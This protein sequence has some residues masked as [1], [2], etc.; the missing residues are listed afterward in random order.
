MIRIGLDFDG[1]MH[2]SCARSHA[3]FCETL[4]DHGLDEVERDHMRS[5]FGSDWGQF[6]KEM[7]IPKELHSTWKDAYQARYDKQPLGDLIEGTHELLDHITGR[8]G[9]KGLVLITNELPDRVHRFMQAHGL[10]HLESTVMNAYSGKSGLLES[11]E[12]TAY[13]GDTVSD[14]LACITARNKPRFFGIANDTSYNMPEMLYALRDAHPEHPI[15]IVR[16]LDEV[17]KYI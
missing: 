4:R 15:Q 10:E 16:R 13:V 12:V 8:Y 7:G 5:Y 1:V 17:R 6:F 9:T 2:D 14:G 3:A 11:Q